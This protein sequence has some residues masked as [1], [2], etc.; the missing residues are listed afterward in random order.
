MKTPT[1]ILEQ[2][3]FAGFVTVE[4][5]RAA[6]DAKGQAVLIL[7]GKAEELASTI[8]FRQPAYAMVLRAKKHVER[9][10]MRVCSD[11]RRNAA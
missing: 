5:M 2:L 10:H 7:A 4:Q 1:A 9:N 8:A 3:A 6:T 11:D